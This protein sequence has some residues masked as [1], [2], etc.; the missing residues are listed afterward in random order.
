M[1]PKDQLRPE[2]RG[3]K[4]RENDNF[5]FNAIRAASCVPELSR[6]ALERCEGRIVGMTNVH[7]QILR[8]E[9]WKQKHGVNATF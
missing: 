8:P 7:H 5:K 2:A 4:G 3:R 1:E 6:N 9:A